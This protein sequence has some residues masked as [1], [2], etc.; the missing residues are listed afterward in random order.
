MKVMQKYAPLFPFEKFV[1]HQYPLD[2]AEEALLKSMEP[3]CMK[4]VIVP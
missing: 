4:V 3:D 1:T 2:Q